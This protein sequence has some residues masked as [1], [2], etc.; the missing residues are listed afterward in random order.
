MK[1]AIAGTLCLLAGLSVAHAD[2]KTINIGVLEDMS[3]LYADATGKGSVVAAEMAV[4]DSGL[5]QKGWTIRIL[6]ADHQNKTDLGVA[7]ARKWIDEDNVDMITGLG[8]SGVAL[9]VIELAKNKN[10]A[11]LVASAGSSDIT[12]KACSPNTTHWT[13]DTHALANSTGTVVTKNGGD[14][15]FLV[16]ADYA[17]GAALDRDVTTAIER[18]GGKVIGRTRHPL[19]TADYSSFLLQAQ[20]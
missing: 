11:A 9:A 10:K 4:E 6:G 14:T 7:I 18:A 19:N 12:G 13:Y 5:T 16:V 17:F 15:W 20:N 3:G 2:P 8:S 1:R